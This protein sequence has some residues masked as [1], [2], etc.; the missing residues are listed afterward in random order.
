MNT[1]MLAA[2][3]VVHHKV[4][5]ES[6]RRVAVT[7]EGIRLHFTSFLSFLLV[8]LHSFPSQIFHG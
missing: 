7:R 5:N 3:R 6:V 4:S 8:V 2:T 1:K